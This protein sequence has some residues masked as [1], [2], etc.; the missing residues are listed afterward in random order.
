MTRLASIVVWCT[1]FASTI[2]AVA[3]AREN[4][5]MRS[6]ESMK[7]INGTHLFCRVVGRGMPIVI[8][9]G[10]PGMDHSYFLPQMLKLAET[11]RLIF[12]DQRASGRS[13]ARVDTNSMTLETLIDDIE[14]VRVAFH[15]GKM[16]LMGHSWGGLLAMFYA[17]KFPNRLN[18]LILSNSTP[19]TSELRLASFKM[20][21]AHT[22]HQDSI[23]QTRIARTE[24]FREKNPSAVGRYL[25]SV[26]RG[27]FY[28][29]HMADSLTLSLCED[30]AAKSALLQYLYREP[31]LAHYDITKELSAIRCPVLVIGAD[32]D[33]I[34][35]E[36]NERIHRAINGS[37]YVVLEHCGHFPF[38]EAPKAFFR[39][40]REFL[41][42]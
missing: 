32:H 34:P 11:H 8:L 42:R 37:K 40:V 38:I 12:F 13:S 18:S 3:K 36:S 17:I 9:H 28:N 5:Q 35:A 21:Q 15:P 27:S 2:G 20:I 25:R 41:A 23:D 1:C 16:N 29:P 22:S 26:F 10:G 4:D 33:I 7:A 6:E 24:E 14:G 30:Y 39:A 19:V 31:R